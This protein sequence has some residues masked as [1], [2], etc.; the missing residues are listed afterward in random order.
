MG[1]LPWYPAPFGGPYRVATPRGAPRTGYPAGV[2]DPG[3]RASDADR[4]RVVAALERH[5]AAGRLT[6][7]EFADRVSRVFGA[8][9]HGDLAVITGDLPADPAADETA[10]DVRRGHARQLALAFVLATLTLVLLGVVLA[11]GR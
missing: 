8:T 11:L 1:L 10:M 9:T 5:T 6:L 3:V 2:N 7:D 4:A